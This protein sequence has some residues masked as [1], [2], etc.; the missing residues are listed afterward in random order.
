MIWILAQDFNASKTD[1]GYHLTNRIKARKS[2]IKY[3][4]KNI[5]CDERVAK[6]KVTK[7][8]KNRFFTTDG[9]DLLLIG[10]KKLLEVA[11]YQQSR[12]YS[13]N[14]S[15]HSPYL[16]F[17]NDRS[18]TI[19]VRDLID[20]SS[21]YNT[22][23]KLYALLAV[24]GNRHFWSRDTHAKI[25]RDS[26]R[27]IIRLTPENLKIDEQFLCI[28]PFGLL[29]KPKCSRREAI[30]AF[31]AAERL[32]RT[33]SK[34]RGRSLIQLRNLKLET[35]FKTY[36]T[37]QLPNL[38]RLDTI[39]R[40][41]PAST[42]GFVVN[43]LS[44]LGMTGLRTTPI[45]C[46]RMYEHG[47]NPNVRIGRRGRHKELPAMTRK[48]MDARGLGEI[49]ELSGVFTAKYLDTIRQIMDEESC[50]KAILDATGASGILPIASASL[51]LH[52][53]KPNNSRVTPEVPVED[54]IE[55]EKDLYISPS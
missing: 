37:L 10:H 42:P 41:V 11:F 55:P 8:I 35:N 18:Y 2:F 50:R 23:S 33:G 47:P 45:S 17:D 21:I 4:C 27:S 14:R 25:L 40:E 39:L 29:N 7:T 20:P 48:F 53:S 32:Y 16:F 13:D 15:N 24:F 28:D 34:V 6:T 43:S 54:Y 52:R 26:R 30:E 1:N 19:C 31:K 44:R 38:Y 51:I 12:A 36:L 9:N 3:L 49:R 46:C 5:G 22:K